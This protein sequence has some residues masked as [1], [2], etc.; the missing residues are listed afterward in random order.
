MTSVVNLNMKL[1]YSQ[2]RSLAMQLSDNDKIA[3]SKELKRA[4]MVLQ[5]Q[6]LKESFMADD[7]SEEVIRQ[8]CEAVRQEMYEKR[9][10]NS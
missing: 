9:I 3:L 5:L 8:E 4:T 2:V 6:E 7:I 10:A 1:D